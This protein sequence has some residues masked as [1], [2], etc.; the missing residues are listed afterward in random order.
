M[1]ERNPELYHLPEKCIFLIS[2]K[3]LIVRNEKFLLLKFIHLDGSDGKWELPGGLKEWGE[4][5]EKRRNRS[6]YR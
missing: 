5:P 4:E 1:A 2:Q 6:L 3:A